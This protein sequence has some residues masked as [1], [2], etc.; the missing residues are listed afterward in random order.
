MCDTETTCFREGAH[1]GTRHR[2]TP[3]KAEKRAADI[4]ARTGHLST[5]ATTKVGRYTL[6]SG[7]A[8]RLKQAPGKAKWLGVFSHLEHNANSGKTVAVV[9]GGNVGKSLLTRYLNPDDLIYLRPDS[10]DA[11]TAQVFVGMSRSKKRVG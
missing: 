11:R 3:T 5:T 8:V 2:F 9:T 4:V 1:P 6:K 7:D 10:K